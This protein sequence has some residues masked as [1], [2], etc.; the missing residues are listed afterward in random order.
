MAIPWH[1]ALPQTVNAEDFVEQ[2][3]AT[4]IRSD[5]EVG[6]AKVRRRFTRSVDIY[7][8]SMTLTQNQNAIFDT[9]YAVNLNGGAT[10]FNFINPRTGVLD[11]FRMVGEPSSKPLGGVHWTLDMRWER[12]PG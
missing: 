5:M 7:S 2:K 12:M 10:S 11:T 4:T 6:P 1:P 8:V 3:G 9:F